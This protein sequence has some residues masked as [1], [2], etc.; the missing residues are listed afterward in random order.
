MSN[1]VIGQEE[2]LKQQSEQGFEIIP[3]VLGITGFA[4]MSGGLVTYKALNETH[5]NSFLKQTEGVG[6]M[7]GGF[8]LG[9]LAAV[10]VT[11]ISHNIRRRATRLT[12]K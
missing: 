4:G 6:F 11:K 1:E 12:F 3:A 2:P 7:G 10:A 8:C 5:Y 9:V